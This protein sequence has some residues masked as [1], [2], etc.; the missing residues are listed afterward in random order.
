MT[1]S[2]D[3]P[4]PS[5]SAVRLLARRGVHYGWVIAAVTFLTMLVTAGAVGAPGVLIAPL[6]REF[7]WATADISSAL[8]VRLMLFGLMGPFA[9]A[10]MNR[11]GVRRVASVALA[12]IAAGILGSFFMTKLWHLVLLWGIVVGLGTGLT[13]MVLGATVATRWFAQRRGL[14]LGLL[15]ASTATGQLVFLPL[16]ASLTES[17]GWRQALILV[18]VMLVVAFVAVLALMRDRPSDIGLAPYGTDTIVPAPAQVAG[19]GAMLMSPLV[20]LREASRTHTFWVLFGT[21]F[22]C[23]ASTNGLVQTHFISLCGDYGMAAT[24]A[25]GVL[26]IIGIFDFAGTVGSGWLSDRYDSRWLLFWYY[27]LRGLSLLYLPFTDF[28]FYGLSLF[29]VFYGLDWV[30]TVPPTIKIA[31]DRFGDKANLVFGWIFAGHQLGA[32]FAAYGAGFSRTVYESYL[33][34]FFIA[35]AL[36][37]FASAAVVTLRGTAMPRLK[38]A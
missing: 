8:A 15:T 33:P 31:A 23:G 37:L 25:A 2:T 19:F 4:S 32:A 30:A 17:V 21:F 16:L 7:G 27:G 11:F 18:L 38:T 20:A 5:S 14:V 34:A 22:V 35:G 36:C 10:F 6:Q 24:T 12:L 28:T 9:A 3:T 1:A 13:A 29:A 26:A